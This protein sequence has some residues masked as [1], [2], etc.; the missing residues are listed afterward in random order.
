[1]TSSINFFL[2]IYIYSLNLINQRIPCLKDGN[3][4]LIVIFFQQCNMEFP[5]ER[6]EICVVENWSLKIDSFFKKRRVKMI[7]FNEY[8]FK[9]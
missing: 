8:I 4:F 5:K 1:M 6:Q 2:Y 9:L 3:N 7:R